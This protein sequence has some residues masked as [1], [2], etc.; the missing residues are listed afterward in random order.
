MKIILLLIFISLNFFSSS[1][2]EK[3]PK[4]LPGQYK[5]H[6]R[7]IIAK[8]GTGQFKSALKDL[9]S[10]L[11]K[12]PD[13]QETLFC[14][15]LTYNKLGDD[16]NALKFAKKSIALGLP[17]ERF[18]AGPRSLNKK[19]LQS[20][21]FLNLIKSSSVKLVHG[22]MIGDLS[23]TSVKIWVRAS[24]KSEIKIVIEGVTAERAQALKANDYTAVINIQGLKPDTF[25]HYQIFQD[26]H[27]I[28]LDVE[29][30]FRTQKEDGGDRIKVIFGG[31]AGFT[32]K[33]ERMWKTIKGHKP[34]ALLLL[35][36]NVY[37][38]H[39]EVRE[40]GQYCYYRRHSR[41]E[42]RKLISSVPVYA[43]WDDH[44]FGTNDCHGGAEIDK[45]NWKKDVWSDFKLQ[46]PNPEYG[47]KEEH[48][49]CYFT[50][51][52]GK[53]VEFIFMDTRYYREPSSGQMLGP[54]QLSWLKKKLKDSKARFKVICSSVPMTPGVK[55]G[56]K[57]TWDGYSKERTEIFSFIKENE[58]N[59]VFVLAAD[60]H[61]SDAWKNENFN[62]NYPIY[63]F[64][65]SKLTNLHTHKIIEG[66][67]FGYN[68]KPSF[69]EM[70]FNFSKDEPT[71]TYT[72]YSIDDE[73]V[74]S[75]EIKLK[76][77]QTNDNLIPND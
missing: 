51:K 30:G 16:E 37:I 71:A 36:D 56:S 42:W 58:I 67:I 53:K 10:Y 3:N 28:D 34:D 41:P 20:D 48:P 44:D 12:E 52:F 9:N 47:G 62:S 65:S 68:K 22:P 43:I 74:G 27:A 61:R 55:P 69:G 73:S 14:L 32:P 1:A 8:L 59:G 26:D 63:E 7:P 13:D 33:Y 2:E 35:G 31:G 50:H 18:I 40:V 11:K 5:K 4:V 49:G 15:S 77:L 19:L 72:A 23:S 54:V 38:D 6:H 45:P 66:C 21:Y 60:R 46:W 25:Y 17:L 70:I 29:P 76:E 24:K 57:D 75:V 64:M 39:P